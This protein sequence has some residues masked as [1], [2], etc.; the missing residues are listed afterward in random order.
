MLTKYQRHEFDTSLGYQATARKTL[1]LIHEPKMASVYWSLFLIFSSKATG[2]IVLNIALRRRIY[3][4]R[5]HLLYMFC[6]TAPALLAI[7]QMSPGRGDT[8][9]VLPFRA[10]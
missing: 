2:T 4:L 10:L 9:P 8:K 5:A 3:S 7:G 6:K 1:L